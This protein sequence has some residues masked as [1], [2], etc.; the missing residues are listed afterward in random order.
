MLIRMETSGWL[1]SK[2]EEIDPSEVG[3]P[4][5]RFYELTATG[6]NAANRAFAEL[7]IK[8]GAASWVSQ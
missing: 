7:E 5:R 4:R 1:T 8:V 3:R 2:W 6:Q